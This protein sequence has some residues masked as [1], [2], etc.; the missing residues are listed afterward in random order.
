MF[1]S[2]RQDMPLHT[3]LQGMQSDVLDTH[4]GCIQPSGVQDAGLVHSIAC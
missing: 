4:S 2:L 1:A 3:Q